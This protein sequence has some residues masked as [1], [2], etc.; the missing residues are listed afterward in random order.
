MLGVKVEQKLADLIV[1][2]FKRNLH[3]AFAWGGSKHF[4]LS[5][6]TPLKLSLIK[7]L[8]DEKDNHTK[9][10]YEGVISVVKVTRHH[11][12]LPYPN[13]RAVQFC[14][15]HQVSGPSTAGAG[16]WCVPLLPVMRGGGARNFGDRLE[17]LYFTPF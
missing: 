8:K 1:E 17:H 2:M 7:M 4:N 10:S 6:S 16:H 15:S 14:V 9:C 12:L 5:K 3:P 11:G 13:L